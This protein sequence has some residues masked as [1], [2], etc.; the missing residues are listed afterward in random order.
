VAVVVSSTVSI[1]VALH[2]M[3]GRTQ[4]AW[5]VPLIWVQ[6][7]GCWAASRC[8]VPPLHRVLV[9]ALL[10]RL[11]LVGTP[12]LLSD[13]LFRYLFEGRALN[14]GLDPFSNPPATLAGFE[15][16]LR[17]QV[18]HPEF[19]SI[20]P[21]LALAWFRVLALVGTDAWVAQLGTALI[22]LG[23]AAALYRRDRMA[24]WLWAL[25]PLPILEAAHGA[26]L[27]ALAVAWVALALTS[28]PVGRV[29]ALGAGAGVKLLPA[30][31][32]PRAAL[33]ARGAFVPTALGALALVAV[34]AAATFPA[35]S[36]GDA[37]TASLSSYARDWS[38]N[39]A[40][41][42]VCA[43][44]LGNW[45][46]PVLALGGGLVVLASLRHDDL[47]RSWLEVALA[48]VLVTPTA[49]PW[50]GLWLLAP[51][52]VMRSVPGILLA[53]AMPTSYLVLA[54]L[55]PDGS[56][57]EAWWLWPATWLPPLILVWLHP[58]ADVFTMRWNRSMG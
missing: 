52:L 39:G 21:P 31:L 10:L 37:S 3:G 50:Y 17:A 53:S 18:N 57:T 27:D 28:P 43:P 48:F 15:D 16:A 4:A 36:A 1:A 7:A 13:D 44:V 12:P 41:Y 46:R 24:G 6:L 58:S 2:V 33:A 32:L 26:H 47:A 29:L 51:A 22:D 35:W 30:L 14:A 34:G 5:V 25:H 23:T 38:F 9:T 54:T 11:A 55:T 40:L 49:H 56:W 45:T 42:T 20:Y 8:G 19:G